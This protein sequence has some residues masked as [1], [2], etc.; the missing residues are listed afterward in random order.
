MTNPNDIVRVRAR[1]GGRASVYEANAWAQGFSAGLLEGNGVT[2][3]TSAD[4][5]VLVGGSSTKPD[6]LIATNPA[7]YKIALDIVGQQAIAITAPASDSRISSI[8]AYTDDL[9]IASE[10]TDVTGSPSSCGLIVV[11]GSTAASPTAPDDTAIRAAITE[12]G[13]TGS[14]ASY[15][16]IAN[17]T[18]ASTT[19]TITDTLISIKRA[20]ITSDKIDF[21]TFN[22]V[23]GTNALADNAVTTAKLAS[24]ID[25]IIS[26]ATV[27]SD[28]ALDTFRSGKK[29]LYGIKTISS[30]VAFNETYWNIYQRTSA[31][32]YTINLGTTIKMESMSLARCE[33]G[34]LLIY[35]AYTRN[36]S[37]SSINVIPVQPLGADGTTSIRISV[38]IWG[39]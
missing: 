22:K 31:E 24:V 12:D 9:A 27:G 37:I 28:F 11:N 13:A 16:V 15:V 17:I 26:T 21:T 29:H 18:V 19:T 38:D 39:S 23:I 1:N 20:A 4:M 8:V 2:Q 32:R 3:N 35:G 6:V 33:W 36:Q 14:Q 10:D 25:P 5:N 7:G 30:G 34:E